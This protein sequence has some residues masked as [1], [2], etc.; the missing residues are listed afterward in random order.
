MK[1]NHYP[2]VSVHVRNLKNL[3]LI[4]YHWINK[5]QISSGNNKGLNWQLAL[6]L[7]W[8]PSLCYNIPFFIDVM[9]D[10]FNGETTAVI[11]RYV[12]PSPW[13]LLSAWTAPVYGVVC[14]SY[15]RDAS[16]LQLLPPPILTKNRCM[17]LRRE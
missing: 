8:F 5:I 4:R 3:N 17:H 11:E 7:C 13:V 14:L 10:W 16:L 15:A 9:H 1:T 2:I 6:H 12:S